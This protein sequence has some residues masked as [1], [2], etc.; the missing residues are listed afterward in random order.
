MSIY[1]KNTQGG[2]V[3]SS[4]EDEIRVMPKK[5]T[6]VVEVYPGPADEII[7]HDAQPHHPSHPGYVDTEDEDKEE[8][9]HLME[10]EKERQAARKR[11][12]ELNVGASTSSAIMRA[13]EAAAEGQPPAKKVSSVAATAHETTFLDFLEIIWTDD[14]GVLVQV[15]V[16]LEIAGKKAIMKKEWQT[17]KKIYKWSS[18]TKALLK[19]LKRNAP[20]PVVLWQRFVKSIRDGESYMTFMNVKMTATERDLLIE[21][22]DQHTTEQSSSSA[23]ITTTGTSS[24]T[25]AMEEVRAAVRDFETSLTSADDGDDD[26]FRQSNSALYTGSISQSISRQTNEGFITFKSP[27][28]C[29]DWVVKLEIIPFA[30]ASQTD[31][32]NWW[33]EANTRATSVCFENAELWQAT[34]AYRK[35]LEKHMKKTPGLKREVKGKGSWSSSSFIKHRQ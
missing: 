9:K 10:A 1:E 17:K 13:A 24:T 11:A 4:D 18:A 3:M 35:A 33:C 12:S 30:H 19:Y 5:G 25:A 22:W 8:I 20:Q 7:L 21:S 27:G 14:V 26:L 6:T 32:G 15:L 2:P 28:E 16:I 34:L 23:I 31:R 29:G